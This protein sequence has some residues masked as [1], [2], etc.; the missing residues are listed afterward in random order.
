L[1]SLYQFLSKRW[2]FKAK[3]CHYNKFY[4]LF[5]NSY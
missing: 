1:F 5:R 2:R 3:Y 4:L